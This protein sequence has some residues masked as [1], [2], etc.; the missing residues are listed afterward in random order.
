VS[1]N[2]RVSGRVAHQYFWQGFLLALASPSAILW[3]ASVGGAV[4]ATET[5]GASG[6]VW[7]FFAGFFAAGVGWSA[8]VA[9]VSARGRR[10]GAPFVRAFGAVSAI[11]FAG[12]AAHVFI[13]GYRVFVSP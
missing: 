5:A 3:F 10:F 8:I 4:I 13:A 2:P 1:G 9:I 7:T 12:L 6:A 11:V